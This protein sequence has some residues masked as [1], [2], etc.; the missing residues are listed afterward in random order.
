MIEVSAPRDATKT[1][2]LL[3]A[4]ALD[5]VVGDA[6]TIERIRAGIDQAFE[7]SPYLRVN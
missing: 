7:Q 4:A 3:W 1:I 2:P 5:G 6:S